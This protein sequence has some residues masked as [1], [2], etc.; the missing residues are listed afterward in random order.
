[1]KFPIPPYLVITLILASTAAYVLIDRYIDTRT[2][3]ALVAV[4]A[5]ITEQEKTLVTVADQ[6]KQNKPDD[7]TKSYLVDCPPQNRDRFDLLLNKLS[8]SIAANELEELRVLFYQCSTYY[9]DIKSIMSAKLT[10]E[11]ALYGEYID[12]AKTISGGREDFERRLE[13]WGKIADAEQNNAQHFADLVTYQEEIIEALR[14]GK[15]PSDAA[16]T[17]ILNKV[18][19][20]RDQM[21]I[22]SQQIDTYRTEA[23]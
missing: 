13:M 21:V 14:A 4:E 11:V 15:T 23:L 5:A 2:Q 20:T 16:I 7:I 10:R 18:Q 19:T 17:D 12:L 1:M 3:A 8:T 22:L 6:T 9:S